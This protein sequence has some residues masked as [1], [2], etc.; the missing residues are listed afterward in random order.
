MVIG[1][2]FLR[3]CIAR[4]ISLYGRKFGERAKVVISLPSL[5]ITW[6]H[7]LDRDITPVQTKREREAMKKEARYI[8]GGMST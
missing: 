2:E 4:S 6:A 7:N 1:L 8:L 3:V 5:A